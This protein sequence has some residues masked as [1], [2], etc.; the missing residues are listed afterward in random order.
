MFRILILVIDHEF[1]VFTEH[2][3]QVTLF[4]SKNKNST[5]KQQKLSKLSHSKWHQSSLKSSSVSS[6]KRPCW[7]T[8]NLGFLRIDRAGYFNY[9]CYCFSEGA[10]YLVIFK[11]NN[12]SLKFTK[13]NNAN[14][15]S[16]WEIKNQY[17]SRR[18]R[19]LVYSR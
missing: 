9:S 19:S 10:A 13:K 12:V 5:N 16:I 17:N 4:D 15:K 14:W 1:T 11:R 6:S 2:Q 8:L 3:A 18:S 7:A